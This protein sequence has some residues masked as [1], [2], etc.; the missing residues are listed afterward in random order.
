MFHTISEFLNMWASESESTLKVLR[1]LSDGSLAQRVTPTGRS[2]GFLAWHI[3]TSV[4]EMG[5]HA[6]LPVGVTGEKD[7]PPSSAAAIAATYEKAAKA[8]ADAVLKNWKDTDL[9]GE[10]PMYGQKWTR[11]ATLGAVIAHQCH[12]RGQATVLM[13]Q[14]G[15]AVPGVYGPAQEEWAAYGMPAQE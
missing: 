12:H 9:P 3:T 13:R 5:K 11:A 10:I 2:L 1:N 14:A 6:G 8:F 7:P 4:S 15:L